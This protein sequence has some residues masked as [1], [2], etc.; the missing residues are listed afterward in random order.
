MMRRPTRIGYLVP[1][2]NTSAQPE[3]DDLRPAGVTNHISR[4]VIRNTTMI[5]Q[6]GFDTV[7]DDI[8]NSAT[9]S[10]ASLCTA[11]PD[12]VVIG[13]SPEGFWSGPHDQ[14]KV[15]AAFE[16]QAGGRPV[17]TSADAITTALSA[18]GGLRRVAIMTPYLALGDT[19]V[20]RF[21]DDQGFDVVAIEGLGAETP[22]A[23]ASIGPDRLRAAVATLNSPDVQAIVQVG[24]N[25][26]MARFAVAAELILDK[27]VLSNNAVLYWHALRRLGITDRQPHA[28]LLFAHH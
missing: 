19:T 25:V 17:V 4:M 28:G 10:I 21:F 14:A 27:P 2:T 13:V 1:S 18:L 12:I 22:E 24:T 7:L 15:V 6:P 16:E 8:R 20:R 3:I 11:N 5:E 9:P 23:I 26:A